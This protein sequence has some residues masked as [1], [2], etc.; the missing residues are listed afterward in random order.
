[1]RSWYVIQFNTCLKQLSSKQDKMFS[2]KS[3]GLE[4]NRDICIRNLDTLRIFG[5]EIMLQHLK[6]LQGFL[7][8][9]NSLYL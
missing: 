5:T 4:V 1:M 8:T 9:L 2:F 6:V 3:E 7:L